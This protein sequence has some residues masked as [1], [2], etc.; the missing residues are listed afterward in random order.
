LGGLRGPPK[1][2]RGFA[3]PWP[4]P[5]PF[6]MRPP[7][8]AMGPFEFPLPFALPA[9]A[10]LEVWCRR[11]RSERRA[12]WGCSWWAKGPC[13]RCDGGGRSSWWG[14][15]AARSAWAGANVVMALAPRY[16]AVERRGDSE[17]EAPGRG[18][19]RWRRY[20]EQVKAAGRSQAAL[21]RM[22]DRSKNKSRRP[23]AYG[24]D[25]TADVPRRARNGSGEALRRK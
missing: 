22:R 20:H 11:S 24:G 3:P 19:R 4:W 8:T 23:V 21:G 17:R 15:S 2:A 13:C 25:S 14:G 12:I 5:C 1:S 18:S 7:G 9:M 6:A 16:E 10:P